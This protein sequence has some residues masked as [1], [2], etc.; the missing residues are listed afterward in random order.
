MAPNPLA[1]AQLDLLSKLIGGERKTCVQ[2]HWDAN[3]MFLQKRL[4]HGDALRRPDSSR[5]DFQDAMFIGY[6]GLRGVDA[7]RPV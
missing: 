2:I 5:D 1:R 3:V 4:R 6:Q 7:H